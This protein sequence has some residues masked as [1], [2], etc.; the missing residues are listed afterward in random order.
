MKDLEAHQREMR[1]RNAEKANKSMQC[2][3]VNPLEG[4][5]DPRHLK[6]RIAE[7][8]KRV[9]ALQAENDRLKAQKTIVVE[10]HVEG[11]YRDPVKE[12]QHNYFKYS[13]LRRY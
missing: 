9:L 1:E 7:L 3:S 8:E 12:Q 5:S 10:R 11:P 2:V 6:K 13:N 4:T